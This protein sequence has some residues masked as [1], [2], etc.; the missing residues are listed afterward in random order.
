MASDNIS[1]IRSARFRAEREEGWARLEALVTK[2]ERR[3][4]QSLNFT[5]ARDLA[6]HYRQATTSLAIAREI[7][8]DKALLDYLEALAARAY[9]SVYAPQERLGGV[10]GRFF[11]KT[12][13]SISSIRFRSFINRR[14]L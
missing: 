14:A 6:S 11:T 10:F 12:A 7:S 9:L 1:L 2:A 5:E 8:L 3:G 13:P 4:A